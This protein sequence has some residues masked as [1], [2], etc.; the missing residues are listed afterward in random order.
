MFANKKILFLFA[1]MDDETISSYGTIRRAADEG[2]EVVICCVCRGGRDGYTGQELRRSVFAEYGHL[3]NVMAYGMLYYDCSLTERTTQEVFNGAVM[4]HRPDIVV[5]H[6]T[7]DLH[8]EHRLLGQAS[9]V[10]CRRI[11][12]SPVRQLWHVSSPME[13]WTYG[14]LERPFTPNLFIDTKKY[15]HAKRQMLDKYAKCELPEFPDLRSAE[16][17]IQYD[18]Q[19]GRVAGLEMAEAYFKV[20]EVA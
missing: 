7:G 13:R 4:L 19:N 20:F 14:Q 8:F 12:D 16:S 11:P 17:V 18:K 15:E 6:W 3:A 10:S 9:L 5:T 2:A 1:H